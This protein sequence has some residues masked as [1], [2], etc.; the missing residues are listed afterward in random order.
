MTSFL[1]QTSTSWANVC[2]GLSFG[3]YTIN[4]TD[5]NGCT[6]NTTITLTE[7]LP[8]VYT[9]DSVKETC[10]SANGQASIT[11]TQGGTGSLGYLWNDPTTQIIATANNLVTGIYTVTVTDINSCSFTEDIFVDEADITLDF[12]SIPPCNGGSDGS[13]TVNPDGT[14]PYQIAWFN[15]DT[16][17]TVTGLAPGFYSVTVVDATGCLVTDSVEVPGSAIVDVTLDVTNSMLN[18]ACFG[19]PSSGVTVIATGGTGA[20]TY[21]YHIPNTFPIPQA[22]N[23]F[24]GLYAGTYPIYATDANGCSDSA[25][26]TISQPDQLVFTTLSEDVSCNGGA[27]GMASIDTIFGGTTSY[28]YLWSTG[29]ITPIISNLTA[30]TYT[31]QAT[32]ANG[33]LSNPTTDTIVINEPSVLQ[34]SITVLS[35][36]YC[37]GSQTLATGE[38]SVSVSG[39][40][41]GYSYLWSTGSISST[42]NLLSERPAIE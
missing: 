25:V 20:N 6:A 12:D 31:V 17:N 10:N 37:A 28:T 34:S 39:G 38:V 5:A 15:G 1:P 24:S 2:G 36:S 8:W 16:T 30:G 23:T 29:E 40:T 35:H 19:Y 21:L 26:V 33:C 18:V 41:A 13:A 7:P 32:D 27:D 22:S 42:V 4:A 9:V 3:A 14:P 11:V